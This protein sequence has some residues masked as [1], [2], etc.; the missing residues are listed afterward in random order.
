ME[1]LRTDMAQMMDVLNGALSHFQPQSQD[2]LQ[3][4]AAAVLS[5]DSKATAGPTRTV[6]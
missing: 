2:E 4:L 3:T 5:H 6:V 1:I